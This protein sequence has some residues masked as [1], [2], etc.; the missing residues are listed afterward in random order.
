MNNPRLLQL[1][2]ASDVVGDLKLITVDIRLC[3]TNFI[4]RALSSVRLLL[5]GFD[6]IRLVLKVN[7]TGADKTR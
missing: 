4:P 3:S 2:W 1:A 5:R 6:G 7:V